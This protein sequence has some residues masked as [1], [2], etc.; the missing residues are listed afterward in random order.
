MEKFDQTVR[1]MRPFFFALTLLA[2]PVFFVSYGYMLKLLFEAV[3][4]WLFIA[5]GLSHIIVW[6]AASMLHDFQKERQSQRQFGQ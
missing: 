2:G 4:N 5:I 1:A 6:I 3:P